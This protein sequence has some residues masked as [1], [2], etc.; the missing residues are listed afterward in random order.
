MNFSSEMFIMS[1]SSEFYCIQSVWDETS[2][3][4]DRLWS[5]SWWLPTNTLHLL[6]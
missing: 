3:K 4:Y 2:I 5:L 1:V 6:Q